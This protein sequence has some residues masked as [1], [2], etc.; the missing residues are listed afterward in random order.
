MISIFMDGFFGSKLYAISPAVRL[1]TKLSTERCLVCSIWHMFLS[2][3]LTVSITGAFVAVTYHRGSVC[4]VI[5]SVKSSLVQLT[6]TMSPAIA[7]TAIKY[8]FKV[9]ISFEFLIVNPNILHS[10]PRGPRETFY[11]VLNCQPAMS[12]HTQVLR[13]LS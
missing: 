1:T 7:R 5:S 6:L 8:S 13:H 4:C 2:P 10:F 11:L 9:F 12:A 3:S